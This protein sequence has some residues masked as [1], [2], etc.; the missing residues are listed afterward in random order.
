[1]ACNGP[2][3]GGNCKWNHIMPCKVCELNNNDSTPKKVCWCDLCKAYICKEH[4][5]DAPERII[6]VVKTIVK[7]VFSRKKKTE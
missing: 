4:I 2:G 7:K 5:N 6:A 3:C 1:M